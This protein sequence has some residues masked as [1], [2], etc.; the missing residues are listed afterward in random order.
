MNLIEALKEFKTL[1][2]ESIEIVKSLDDSIWE[3]EAEHPEYKIYTPYI[4]LRHLLM[5]DYFHMYKIEE[6]WLTND[7]YLNTN[8]IAQSL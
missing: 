7:E 4:M 3:K 5:H 6:L 2:S 8:N 1:R